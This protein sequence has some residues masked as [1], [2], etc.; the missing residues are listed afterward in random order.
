MLTTL[1]GLT[2]QLLTKGGVLLDS[3]PCTFLDIHIPMDES[4]IELH[5][6]SRDILPP[7]DSPSAKQKNYSSKEKV[8]RTLSNEIFHRI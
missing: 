4:C 7:W 6:Q 3:A 8:S 1:A 5:E 2:L